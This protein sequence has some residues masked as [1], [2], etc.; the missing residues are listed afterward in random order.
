M[1]ADKSHRDDEYVD[2]LA[3]PDGALHRT[4][5]VAKFLGRTSEAVL[6][7][8]HRGQIASVKTG[9]YHYIPTSEVRDY[10]ERQRILHGRPKR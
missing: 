10:L 3:A 8:I 5:I 7:M 9:R 1:D 2:V 4:A 6:L